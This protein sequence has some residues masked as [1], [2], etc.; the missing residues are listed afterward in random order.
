MHGP[1]S[2]DRRERA[3]PSPAPTRVEALAAGC[4]GV[5]IADGRPTSR[6]GIG[7]A[8]E[9]DAFVVVAQV[10]TAAEALAGAIA[11]Q[12]DACVVDVAIP[13]GGLAAARAITAWLPATGVVVLTE[14][15]NEEELLG[16][17]RA[18]A[19]GY[20]PASISPAR[21]RA[22][23]R[24]V[25]AGDA[26]IP[27]EM[28]GSLLPAGARRRRRPPA[29]VSN[30][31]VALSPREWEAIELLRRGLGTREIADELDI[32]VVTVRRHLSEALR[33]L[34]APDRSSA[35]RLLQ[36]GGEGADAG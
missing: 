3:A 16:A 13:G 1:R 19:A 17:L 11:R 23:V 12:P 6:L 9:D 35:L 36:D 5:L 27:R 15:P 2:I 32:S 25:V 34:G 4:R 24:A 7:A 30:R 8:L 28:I 31:E 14:R 10:A 18:G 22:A 26:V 33:K 21:L 20:L 29:R